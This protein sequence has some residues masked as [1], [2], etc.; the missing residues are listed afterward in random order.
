MTDIDTY[1]GWA[2]THCATCRAQA[3]RA[4][5]GEVFCATCE[6]RAERLA[7]VLDSVATPPAASFKAVL[8]ATTSHSF[9]VRVA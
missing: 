7:E 4:P 3:W 2:F 8:L 5:D 6:D 1:A 9:P